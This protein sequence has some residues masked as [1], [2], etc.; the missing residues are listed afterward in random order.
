MS[1]PLDIVVAFDATGSMSSCIHLVRTSIRQLATTLFEQIPDLRFGV[2]CFKD[3]GDSDTLRT[4]DLTDNIDAVVYFLENNG[5]GGGGSGGRHSNEYDEEAYESA[6][7]AVRKFNFRTDPGTKRIFL[8]IGDSTPH[9]VGYPGNADHLD[10]RVELQA[11]K[12][13][14]IAVY[15][16]Q[17]MTYFPSASIFYREI[18]ESFET[19]HLRMNQ[20]AYVIDM[21]TAVCMSAHSEN[22]L[23]DF[24]AKVNARGPMNQSMQSTLRQLRGG[25]AENAP[26]N[27][28][29]TAH[30]STS[31]TF[32]P[33]PAVETIVS[34]SRFQMLPVASD[35]SIKNFVES[36]ALPF[37]TG[38]GF[39]ELVK[40]EKISPK[41]EIVVQ[42]VFTDV[43]YTGTDARNKVAM[44]TTSD[45]N[46][47][48][49]DFDTTKWRVFIQSTS[50]NRKLIGGSIFLYE[51]Q[52]A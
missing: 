2:V 44:A 7:H 51:M 23:A 45:C 37:K 15:P 26:L 46:Y 32:V 48:Q 20:F 36:N 52:V 41:K 5:H 9:S 4:I 10:Y 33:G 49:K 31:T 14:N 35:I 21:I 34:E 29:F 30:T 6:F 13:M 39:Y 1:T 47:S 18:S 22:S 12:D 43:M 50:Y 24:E 42:D 8:L 28:A 19:P 16:V 17:A 40:R 25:V 11:L 3:Y 27:Q 38:R